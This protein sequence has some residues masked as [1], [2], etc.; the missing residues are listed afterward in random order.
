MRLDRQTALNM[1]QNLLELKRQRG[2]NVPGDPV[3]FY[4]FTPDDISCVHFW[5]GEEEGTWFRLHDG[6]VI[7]QEGRPAEA[8]QTLYGPPTSPRAIVL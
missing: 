2:E 4:G 3:S 6:R 8:D 1:M 7:D 5:K